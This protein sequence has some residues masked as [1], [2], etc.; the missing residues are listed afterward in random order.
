MGNR[1][2]WDPMEVVRFRAL[3][4]ISLT[5][6]L[7][8]LIPFP[9]SHG[10]LMAP[11]LWTVASIVVAVMLTFVLFA[12]LVYARAPMV[13]HGSRP[14]SFTAIFISV[15]VIAINVLNALSVGFA[16]S[17]TGYFTGL[18][19]LL[20]LAGLYFIRLIVL[21]GPQAKREPQSPE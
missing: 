3:I 8:A 19:F 11:A 2:Q 9:L 14:W 6:A 15:L 20:I 16:R 21:S 4:V 17:F 13:T 10:G 12:M 5:S 7:I 18:L 1:K